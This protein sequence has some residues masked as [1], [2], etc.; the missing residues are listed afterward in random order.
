M[1]KRTVLT[2]VRMRSFQKKCKSPGT[3][4]VDE[5]LHPSARAASGFLFALKNVLACAKM[6]I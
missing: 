6:H 2:T 1:V 5:F 4:R 3:Q